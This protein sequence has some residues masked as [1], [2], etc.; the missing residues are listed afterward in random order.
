MNY[1]ILNL[2]RKKISESTVVLKEG[3]KTLLYRMPVNVQ[4][5][6]ELEKTIVCNLQCNN[7]DND[8]QWML[9]LLRE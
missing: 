2:Q 8:H 5:I 6:L 3:G 9:K 7:L 4:R 1:N